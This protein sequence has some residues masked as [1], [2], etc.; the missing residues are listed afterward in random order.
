MW[1]ALKNQE[2]NVPRVPKEAK[3][4]GDYNQKKNGGNVEN[5][6]GKQ[7]WRNAVDFCDEHTPFRLDAS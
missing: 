4:L 7:P 1:T 5:A 6:V 2:E 3:L